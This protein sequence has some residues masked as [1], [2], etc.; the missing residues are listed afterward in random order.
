M[1]KK[2]A[3]N[4][5]LIPKEVSFG[6]IKFLKDGALSGAKKALLEKSSCEEEIDSILAKCEHIELHKDKE[7]EEVFTTSMYF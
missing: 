1:D 7:F 3:R 2:N 6:I 5:G 4:I